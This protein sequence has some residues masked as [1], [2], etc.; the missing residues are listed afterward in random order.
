M[1]PFDLEDIHELKD[2]IDS[3]LDSIESMAETV[4]LYNIKKAQKSAIKLSDELVT[5]CELLGKSMSCLNKMQPPSLFIDE[6]KTSERAA[7]RIF[8]QSI[9]DLF[10]SKDINVLDVIKWKDLYENLE[11]YRFLQR[12]G[13]DY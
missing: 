4:A 12:S 8:R 5:S 3:I 1:T 2:L 9:A 11:N 7:D 6:I 13:Y 10:T